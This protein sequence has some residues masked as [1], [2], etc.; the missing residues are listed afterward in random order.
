MN[1]APL[2]DKGQEG[3]SKSASSTDRAPEATSA[4]AGGD[5][6]TE[7]P[8]VKLRPALPVPTQQE[9]DEH[10]ASGHAIYRPWCP[11]CV[12]GRGRSEKHETI[13]AE[14]KLLPTVGSDYTFLA[15]KKEDIKA[16]KASPLLVSICN[17]SGWIKAD[18][19]PTK[20]GQNK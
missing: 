7:S 10:R 16:E 19:L 3:A 15:E 17:K 2:P 1:D 20:S 18:T 4:D 12:G 11:P 6:D 8:D 13:D 14:S 9:R 5:P